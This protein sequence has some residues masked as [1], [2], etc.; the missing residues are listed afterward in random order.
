M[1]YASREIEASTTEVF[2]ILVD[3]ATYP[4]WLAGASKMRGID[5]DW[6]RIGSR[7][8]HRVGI[9]PLTIADNSEVLAIESDRMLRLAVRARPLISAVV[10]FT[11]LGQGERCVVSFEEE[12]GPRA[13]GNLIRPLLDPLTHVRNHIS[14]KRLGALVLSGSARQTPQARSSAG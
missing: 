7:F 9:G 8:H 10:T 2:A 11:L 13:I 6:P 5:D 4:S 12:P 14:L 1:A 3:P